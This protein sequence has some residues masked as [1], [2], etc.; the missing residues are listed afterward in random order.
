MALGK[1]DVDTYFGI[2]SR[3]VFTAIGQGISQQ[4]G[5]R[6]EFE[7]I[8]L[9][10]TN[11]L[12]LRQGRMETVMLPTTTEP[13]EPFFVLGITAQD[14]GTLND[15]VRGKGS[16]Q[17]VM[18]QAVA[19]A[20]EPFNFIT[21]T[22]NTLSGLRFSRNVTGLTAHHLHGAMNYTQAEGL[23]RVEQSR[24]FRLCLL[25][26][27]RGR[28]VIEERAAQP[29]TQR[30]FFSIIS[31][32]YQ[33]KPQLKP[34]AVTSSE[35]GGKGLTTTLLN[36]WLNTFFVLNDGNMPPK[37]LKQPVSFTTRAQPVA[38][39]DQVAAG[40]K[41]LAVVRLIL[42]GEKEREVIILVPEQAER[43]LLSLSKSGQSKF[44]GDFFRIFFS[45]AAETWQHFSGSPM[46]W[47]LRAL[48]R[49][50]QEGIAGL[51][52]RAGGGGLLVEQEARLDEGV[53]KWLMVIPPGTW[54]W[55]QS[56]TASA[57]G[58]E[59]EGR[60]TPEPVF[61]ATGW[62]SLF[63]NW[64]K[65][66]H[67]ATDQELQLIAKQM[68][69]DRLDE[70]C[71]AAIA[72]SLPDEIRER[73][74]TALPVRL[75]EQTEAHQVIEEQKIFG[76]LKSTEV[77]VAMI[78]KNRLDE[79]PLTRWIR[80][81]SEILWFRRHLLIEKRLPF[82]HLV[83]GMD[84]D[85]LSRFLFGLKNDEL[86]QAICGAEFPVIDQVRRAISPGYAIRLFEDV[87]IKRPKISAWANQ[88]ARLSLYRK[89]LE[90][91]TSGKLMMRET[92]ATRLQE[93]VTWLDFG[94]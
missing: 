76:L 79:S 20:I 39:L 46:A 77:V 57:V 14:I 82:R 9:S 93:I 37:I 2:F 33:C 23:F 72:N 1:V 5:A 11:T 73:W 30:A 94:A 67:F 8:S 42:N 22:K 19:M 66:L 70:S 29:N 27:A 78:R 88:E 35:A 58:M 43:S 71:T 74:L 56:L 18:E 83:Y 86:S 61:L 81:F 64:E 69:Q 50:P 25:V 87:E 10:M 21:K 80:L 59:L 55:L 90:D 53:V 84:R 92:P 63:L 3:A 16:L 24:E 47:S 6:F 15:L 44:L 52:G 4:T 51:K 12:R 32:A 31:G 36:G 62:D 40:E 68:V 49:L 13:V 75:R 65:V 48:G 26:T 7:E 91:L 85:S 54:Q 17:R 45:E 34:L 28:D 38:A 41:G 89:C 60:P